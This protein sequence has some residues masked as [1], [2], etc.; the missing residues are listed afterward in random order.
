[1]S[2]AFVGEVSAVA[3]TADFTKYNTITDAK[4]N[5]SADRLIDHYYQTV[6]TATDTQDVERFFV[7]LL[8]HC[9]ADDPKVRAFLGLEDLP[10]V[11]DDPLFP[12]AITLSPGLKRIIAPFTEEI[13]DHQARLQQISQAQRQRHQPDK[14]AILDEADGALRNGMR[15]SGRDRTEDLKDALRM[16]RSVLNDPVSG[17]DYAIWFNVGWILWQ[18]ESNLPEAEEAFYQAAR[19]S[20]SVTDLLHLYSLRHLAYMEALQGKNREAY[21]TITKALAQSPDDADLL[22]DAGR[23]AARLERLDNGAVL[24]EKAFD[25]KPLFLVLALSEPDFQ[26]M[27]LEPRV[28]GFLSD[29]REKAIADVQTERARFQRAVSAIREAAEQSGL[30]ITLPEALS[31]EVESASLPSGADFFSLRE[32]APRIAHSTHA[33][34]ETANG[35]LQQNI[36]RISGEIEGYQKQVDHIKKNFELWRNTIKWIEREAKEAGFSLKPGNAMDEMKLRMQKKLERVRDAR[37]NYDQAKDNLAQA[38]EA[39]KDQ[40]PGLDKNI[41]EAKAHRQKL[42]AA[43]EWLSAQQ[44]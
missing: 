33:A 11:D 36:E 30:T 26:E 37:A 9:G 7:R 22:Y 24:M 29:R 39:V 13:L 19:L 40:I 2:T 44:I 32:M 27:G 15:G 6:C 3:T 35:V 14:T 5:V 21:V 25:A 23:Y 43:Q 28:R 17:R 31:Q 41:A 18:L 38:V 4:R 20:G 12:T 42:I 16:Y 10:V 8:R 34:L 1:M